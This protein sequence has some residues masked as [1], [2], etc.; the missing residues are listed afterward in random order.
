MYAPG[1]SA[2]VPTSSATAAAAHAASATSHHHHTWFSGQSRG[3]EIL[4]AIIVA[5]LAILAGIAL[6]RLA[7]RWVIPRFA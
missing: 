1:A 4:M 2:S 5:N 6:W 3:S 7:V